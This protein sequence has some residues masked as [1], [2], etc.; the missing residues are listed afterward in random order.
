MWYIVLD[1]KAYCG[2]V[3]KQLLIVIHF[4]CIMTNVKKALMDIIDQPN[5]SYNLSTKL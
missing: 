2:I 3:D 1:K 4:K 5:S